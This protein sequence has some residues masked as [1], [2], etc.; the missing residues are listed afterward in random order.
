MLPQ[1]KETVKAHNKASTGPVLQ[2][3]EEVV[4]R[5]T[6]QPPA[7]EAE[8]P[9]DIQTK[10]EQFVANYVAMLTERTQAFPLR[11]DAYRREKA[12]VEVGGPVLASGYQYWNCLTV[13]PIQFYGNPPYQPSKIIAAGEWALMLGVVWINPANS[14]GGGLPGT[15]VLGG[16]NYRVRFETINLTDVTNG[17]D[18]LFASAFDNPAETVNVFRWWFQPADPGPDPALYETTLTADI[19]E[20]GQPLA[21]FSTWH[22]DIDS[23]PPFMALPP[24]PAH[25]QYEIPARFLVYRR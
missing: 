22:Y 7:P 4:S 10:S 2:K 21:A 5:L 20:M 13:G 19:V 15:I 1:V 12:K 24:K 25:W 9:E 16:R 18:H 17:P 11:M 23:E 14:D 3:A 8:L 6:A